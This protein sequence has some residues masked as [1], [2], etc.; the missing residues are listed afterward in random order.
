MA[1][2]CVSVSHPEIQELA[3]ITKQHPAIVAAKAAIWQEKNNTLDR[4]PKASDI[5]TPEFKTET[6]VVQEKLKEYK[7]L[8]D[9]DMKPAIDKKL[10]D[11]VNKNIDN[12]TQRIAELMPLRGGDSAQ[13]AKINIFKLKDKLRE[14]SEERTYEKLAEVAYYQLEEAKRIL[15]DPNL[16]AFELNEVKRIIIYTQNFDAYLQDAPKDLQEKKKNIRDLN[17]ALNVQFQEKLLEALFSQSKVTGLEYSKEELDKAYVDVS[18]IEAGTLAPEYS[19]IP[20]AKIIGRSIDLMNRKTSEDFNIDFKDELNKLLKE[21]GKKKFETSDFSEIMEDNKLILEFSSKYFKDEKEL[22]AKHSKLLNEYKKDDKLKAQVADSFNQIFK[23]YK[24]NLDYYITSESIKK[25]KE[26][27]ADFK[28]AFLNSNGEEDARTAEAVQKWQAVNSP[29]LMLGYTEDENGDQTIDIDSEGKVKIVA[30]RLASTKIGDKYYKNDNWHKYLK[31]RPRPQYLNPKWAKASKNPLHIFMLEK[32]VEAIKMLPRKVAADI[33]NYHRFLDNFSLEVTASDNRLKKLVSGIKNISEETFKIQVNQAMVDGGIIKKI[34]KSDGTIEEEFKPLLRTKDERGNPKPQITHKTIENIKKTQQFKDPMEILQEFYKQAV[35]YRHKTVVAP[36]LDLLQYKVETTPGISTN[37]INQILLDAQGNPQLIENGLI[38]TSGQ[39]RYAINSALSGITRTDS[40]LGAGVSKAQK[41][42]LKELTDAWVAGGMQGPAPTVSVLSK[43]K[44]SDALVDYTRMSLIGLKPFTAATN[45]MLG[46]M[47]NYV[48]AARGK[49]FTEKNLDVAT[50][51]L[52]GNVFKFITSKT[53]SSDVKK[54]SNLA[55]KFGITNTLYESQDPDVAI[56]AK[57]KFVKF[58][59]SL[60][61][62]GEFLI[63]NQTMIAMMLNAKITSK[64]GKSSSLW[65]AYNEEGNLKPEFQTRE[66]SSVEVINDKGDNVSKLNQFRN[67]LDKIRKRTQGDYQSPMK[68]KGDWY[69]RII[70]M[71]RTWVPQAIKERFGRENEDFKGRYTSYA[72]VFSKSFKED[73]FKGLFETLGKFSLTTLAKMTNILPLGKYRFDKL[74]NSAKAAFDEYLDKIGASELDVENMRANIKE[75]QFF[76]TCTIMILGIS[77]LK[78]DD[79][80][81]TSNFLINIMYRLRQDLT[82][83]VSP[84]SALSV[85][86][87]PLPIMK[88]IKD[89]Q[90]VLGTS[91]DYLDKPESRYYQKGYN[92]GDLK[93]WKELQD[94]LPIYS[95]VNSTQG[96]LNTVFNSDSY[97]YAK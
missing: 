44:V 47:N 75:L 68:V 89:V 28:K 17:V 31:A 83:F 36:M 38:N 81:Q 51:L 40:N 22:W 95:A 66:W 16:S 7:S 78:G 71:F 4:F 54:I 26:D 84:G 13:S 11:A 86:K 12:L 45:L 35:T 58:L 85:I 1:N 34:V 18:G 21:L 55:E 96:V 33:G 76:L 25:Y 77:G 94:L 27:L 20:L 61:E 92:K 37:M 8:L 53:I 29:Y 23:W 24:D 67:S 52:F 93:V 80:D 63:A 88:T 69:G 70:M 64:E 62:G 46:L 72:D 91:W 97:K 65:D 90:D 56:R 5:S 60:Q 50:K 15:K 14:L 43:V 30:E 48:Y 19:P 42:K 32:Y 74:D 9:A 57:N 6:K 2:H 87:D 39:T 10:E 73:G 79:D 41:E 49:E 59:F 82:A 3:K